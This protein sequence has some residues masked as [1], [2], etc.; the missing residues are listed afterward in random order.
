MFYV[1]FFRIFWGP[2]PP[3]KGRAAAAMLWGS[4]V[5]SA[6]Q[7]PLRFAFGLAFGHPFA[8]LGHLAFGQGGLAASLLL[9]SK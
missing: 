6:L 9:N 1:A 8:A 5:C 3:L 7:A 4:Q 2:R